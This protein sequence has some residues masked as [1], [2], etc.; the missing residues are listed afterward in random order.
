M[1]SQIVGR[2]LTKQNIGLDTAAMPRAGADDVIIKVSSCGI[3][4]TDLAI[5]RDGSMP[6]GTIL[7]HEFSGMITAAGKDVRGLNIGDRVTANPM[8]LGLGLGRVSGAF[9]QHVQ[10]SAPRLG[11]NIFKLP[12]AMADETGALIEPFAVGLHAVTRSRA[13]PGER[14]V[15]FGAGT[16]GLCV[17][18]AL[19]AR[20]VD[21]I[22]VVE[23][24]EKRLALAAAFGAAALHD[25][26]QGSARAAAGRRFGEEPVR[27]CEEPLANADIVFDC[28]GV[29]QTL[30][31]GIR[32]LAPNGRLVLVAD[33]HHAELPDFR[34][35]LLRELEIIGAL[36]YAQEFVE[37]IVLLGEGKIDL[38]PLITHRFALEDIAEAFRVQLDAAQSVKVLVVPQ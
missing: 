38:S 8:L 29:R 15:I 23:P 17:L 34:L 37:A 3:C 4:G 31:D 6:P 11:E 9:A 7:G 35:V 21:D 18:A 27:Y 32:A 16:I 30:Q 22:L 12:D 24:N 28:A 13:A 5:Y 26:R 25:P 10:I 36:A 1:E 33:P 2:L 20:G 19:R 14:V